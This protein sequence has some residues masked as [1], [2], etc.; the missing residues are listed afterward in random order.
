[1]VPPPSGP[2]DTEDS[3]EPKI[4]LAP[5]IPTKFT[6]ITPVKCS[7]QNWLARRVVAD[8][9]PNGPAP[10]NFVYRR[11]TPL[12]VSHVWAL[13]NVPAPEDDADIPATGRPY[14]QPHDFG[15]L[16]RFT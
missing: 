9:F 15:G 2:R 12:S 5:G 6:F 8:A 3:D 11:P 14:F 7:E 16:A 4:G 1:M 13:A 10:S